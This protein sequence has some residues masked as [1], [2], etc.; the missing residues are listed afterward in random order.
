[1]GILLTRARARLQIVEEIMGKRVRLLL[2]ALAVVALVAS[3]LI[4]AVT[5]GASITPIKIGVDNA[6]PSGHNFEYVDF[7]P[8]TGTVVHNGDIVDFAWN[9]GAVDGFHTVS[10]V[11][12]PRTP[13]WVWQQ[14]P[15]I[16]ADADDGA[17]S[18]QFNTEIFSNQPRSCV[19]D[20]AT[21][22][23][24]FNGFNYVSSAGLPNPQNGGPHFFVK[25]NLNL[26]E[27][28]T[29]LPVRVKFVCLIHPGMQGSLLVAPNEGEGSAP[30]TT[31][32]AS[33]TLTT[34]QLADDTADALV[35]ETA[36]NTKSVSTNA[37]GTHTITMSAGTAT[38]RV[39]VLEMLPNQVDIK[40]GDHVK[41][42]TTAKKDPHTVTFP[43]GI[44]SNSVDPF[45]APVCEGTG[46]TDTPVTAGP[47]TF[48]CTE[49]TP[50]EAPLNWKPVGDAVV[51]FPATAT[52]P[53]VASSGI[54]ATFE[55]APFP[56][57]YTFTFPNAGTFTY[58]CRIHDHMVGT[59]LVAAPPAAPPV[60]AQTG[61]GSPWRS[62]P[63]LL[64]ALALLCGLAVLRL[65]PLLRH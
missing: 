53:T 40:P 30:A 12:V 32:A 52:A 39:E 58:M 46:T 64:G 18:L 65:R 23:C 51:K 61:G 42:V 24:T 47:P 31:Q 33:D 21:H 59:V 37:D 19:G 11:P 16:K 49:T 56:N 45:G 48:G 13:Q 1:M 9:P 62:L 55:Q 28:E 4:G 14:H 41:W 17:D 34:A 5:V 38:S 57:N 63:V 44:G 15:L 22:A 7:F 60:L 3:L 8:R 36:A 43:N 26:S 54:I 2:S 10:F 6:G 20:S 29:S 27:L 25:V 50:L 35:A